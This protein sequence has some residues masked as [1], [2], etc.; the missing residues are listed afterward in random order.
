MLVLHS[1]RPDHHDRDDTHHH[2]LNEHQDDNHCYHDH[3]DISH[4]DY[5]DHDIS[6]HDHNHCY[7]DHDEPHDH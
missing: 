4:Y 6:H 7:D 3:D 1:S 5:N 2:K